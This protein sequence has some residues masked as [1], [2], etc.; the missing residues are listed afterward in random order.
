MDYELATSELLLNHMTDRGFVLW[1][2][3]KEKIPPIWNRPSSSTG[4]YHLNENGN[5][6]TII[7]H[8]YEMLN[9]CIKTMRLLKVENKT[10]EADILLLAILLHD[11]FK[12]GMK[13][14]LTRYYTVKDHDRISGDCVLH[15]KNLFTQYYDEEQINILEECVR[16]HSG[17][18]STDV[19][20]KSKFTFSKLKPE[21]MFIHM[22]DMLSTNNCL[23]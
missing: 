21:T 11:A 10:K 7:E 6:Q 1:V 22:L 8:T 5:V 15:Q 20:D 2:K 9:S 14:P 23:R 17:Q 18:W 4:K 12:Y 19:E 16:Y 13:D 3:L